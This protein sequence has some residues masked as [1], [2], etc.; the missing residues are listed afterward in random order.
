[1]DQR[2]QQKSDKEIWEV[3][4]LNLNYL[5]NASY[6]YS[7]LDAIQYWS[8]LFLWFFQL[9]YFFGFYILS[10]KQGFLLYSELIFLFYK[11]QPHPCTQETKLVPDAMILV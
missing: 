4:M 11:P 8:L 5:L 3:S 6:S 9:F 7:I 2:K 10:A 1:M